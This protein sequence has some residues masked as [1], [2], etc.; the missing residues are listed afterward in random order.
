MKINELFDQG[1]HWTWDLRG[2]EEAYAVFTVGNDEYLWFASRTAHS[3]QPYDWT[4]G[5]QKRGQRDRE[6]AFGMSGSDSSTQVMS[7]VTDITRNFLRQ[8]GDGV[9][10]LRFSSMGGSRTSLYAKMAQRLLPTWELSTSTS[11]NGVET[12]FVLTNPK[13]RSSLS[14][15]PLAD[16]QPIGDFTKP[17]PFRG[18]DKKLVP[19]PT[20]QLK[21]GQFFE[22]T[23]YDFRL[24][25]SNIP[26]TGKY[27]ET[28]VVDA[29]TIQT[30][31]KSDPDAAN[32]ILQ[33]SE[34]AITVVFVGNAGDRKVMM[35]PWIMA[36]RIGHAIQATNRG[37]GSAYAWKEAEKHF[38][39]NVNALM[40]EFYKHRIQSPEQ[41]MDMNRNS[42]QAYAALFNAIGTQR[43]SRTGQIRRPYEFMY[44]LFA[45][46]LGTG[47]IE[48]NPLPKSQGYGQKVFGR[49]VRSLDMTPGG[50]EDSKYSTEVLGRDMELMFNDVLSSLVGSILVM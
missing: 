6:H 41:Q 16:Y 31:F 29:A 34:D 45:Q 23:P 17:G 22:K 32:T 40:R 19:H 7:I 48:L 4:V 26:G 3:D 15:A 27:S 14:E 50:E 8:Y 11:K 5:F 30:M 46:Y 44:E 1:K 21:A 10:A 28:G 13:T 38:F 12:D 2:G 36:H 18:V 39:R 37:G 20:N 9:H 35:T 24:F 25:F 33:G 49:T 43:S 47:R 42:Q